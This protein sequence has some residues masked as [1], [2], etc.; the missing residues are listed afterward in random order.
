MIQSERVPSACAECMYVIWRRLA[1]GV[2]LPLH[3]HP[4]YTVEGENMKEKKKHGSDENP[5]TA[6]DAC[7]H[8]KEATTEYQVPSVP[9]LYVSSFLHAP[10]VKNSNPPFSPTQLYISLAGTMSSILRLRGLVFPIPL[11][12]CAFNS[13]TRRPRAGRQHGI[14]QP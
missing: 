12:T 8:E 7:L 3:L 1:G 11:L 13:Y 4:R 2:R 14:L 9:F 10:C 6:S 5:L